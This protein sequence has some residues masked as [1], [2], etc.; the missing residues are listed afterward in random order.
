MGRVVLR[1]LQL[2]GSYGLQPFK[3]ADMLSLIAAGRLH[4]DQLIGR[5]IS[6]EEGCAALPKMDSF[7]EVGAAIID[8][9]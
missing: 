6:L 2:L 8:R 4:P 9:F 1:E 5:R 7:Q 3:Y